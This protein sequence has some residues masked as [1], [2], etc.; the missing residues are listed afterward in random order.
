M[1]L[2]D[3]VWAGRRG[4]YITVYR[5]GREDILSRKPQKKGSELGCVYGGWV[6]NGFGRRP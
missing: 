5:T 3:M 4:G 2:Y 6:V 1:W